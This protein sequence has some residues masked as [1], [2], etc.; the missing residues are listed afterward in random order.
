M[1]LYLQTREEWRDWL[2]RNHKTAADVWLIYYK[3]GSGKST[4]KYSDA[5]EE[6]ICFG[7][8][9]GKIKSVNKDYYIQRYTP[10]RSGSRW[11][12]YN[13]DRVQKMISLGKMEPAGLSSFR[14]VL[15]KPELVYDN[16][17]DGEPEIPEDLMEAFSSN[18]KA[19][20]NFMNFSTSTRRT[21]IDWL[22]SAKKAETRP[23]RINKI[24]Y[25]SEQNKR[26][27]MI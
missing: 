21:Y 19:F 15:E 12:K 25:S 18:K 14:E 10:R 17:S 11:S 24:I 3:K 4:I 8:I 13:I 7:W 2:R 6:A 26:P 9:D 1:E 16:R 22:N 5:V 27:G 20:G 23:G